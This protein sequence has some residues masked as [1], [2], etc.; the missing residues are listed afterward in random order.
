MIH[1]ASG[2]KHIQLLAQ[3]IVTVA[4]D[5]VFP[6]HCVHCER[7]GSFLCERCS[8]TV[9]LAPKRVVAGLDDVFVAVEFS[10]AASAA[11]HAFKYERQTQLADILGDWLCAVL[12]DV[13]MSV[14]CVVAVPLHHRRFSMRGYNQAA[15]LAHYVAKRYGW[16]FAA[17]AV[18]RVRE[19]SSQVH[20]NAQERRA[21]V[22]GAFAAQPDAVTGQRVLL[23][24]D[25][26]TTGA[27]LAACAG[28]LRAAGAESVIGATVASAMFSA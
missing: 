12:H 4:L 11:I 23:V 16:V 9:T 15:L 10:G 24:D 14:D 2:R 25:V 19:T 5:L 26:L 13:A 20:L 8:R 7:V 18:T 6:P 1:A 27:T 17:N 21:N 28:A 3:Q 22:A